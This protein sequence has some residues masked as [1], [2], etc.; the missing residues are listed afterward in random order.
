MPDDETES[1]DV[2]RGLERVRIAEVDLMLAMG[3]LMVRCLYL[4]SHLLENIHDRAACVFTEIDRCEV[5][6]GAD[7]VGHRRRLP[8][9]PYL[10]HEKFGFHSRV[11]RREAKVAGASELT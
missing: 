8:V 10:E 2:V 1:R 3:D 9:R 11:H 7:I 4:E 5:E 6:V